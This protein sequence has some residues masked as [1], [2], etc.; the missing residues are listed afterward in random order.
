MTRRLSVVLGLVLGLAALAA[1][2]HTYSSAASTGPNPVP[3]CAP[4]NP[5]CGLN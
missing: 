1:Q 5:H 2:S 4:D 3:L